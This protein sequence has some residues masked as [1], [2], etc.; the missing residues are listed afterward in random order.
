M[1][2]NLQ[3][4]EE[5]I[6]NIKERNQRV[7]TDK[8]WERSKFRI[9]TLTIIT[10]CITALLLYLIGATNFYLAALIPAAGF[11][12]SVQSLPAIKNWWLKKFQWAA[13]RKYAENTVHEFFNSN[14]AKKSFNASITR[15][16]EN[17]YRA[18]GHH[19]KTFIASS[20]RKD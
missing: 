14:A 4:L 1:A 12:L 10:Y 6:R 17:C 11:F 18:D 2:D 7:E 15:K 13:Q 16:Q 5:E 8:A 9:G 19:T 3:K 20:A